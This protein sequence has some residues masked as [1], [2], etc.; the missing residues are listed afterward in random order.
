M[1]GYWLFRRFQ[2]RRLHVAFIMLIVWC[3]IVIVLYFSV[4][5]LLSKSISQLNRTLRVK[6]VNRIG[7]YSSACRLPNLDPFHPSILEYMR[8]LGKLQC[9]VRERYSTFKNNVVQV[10]GAGISA[11]QYRTIDRPRGDDFGVELSA[12]SNLWNLAMPTMQPKLRMKTTPVSILY[13]SVL[14]SCLKML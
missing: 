2:C 11:V 6:Y 10:K 1:F 13:R 8:D 9:S 12:P 7:N 4:Y 5:G 14:L 3:G